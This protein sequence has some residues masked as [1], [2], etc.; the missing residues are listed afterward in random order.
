MITSR[1][2]ILLSI[3]S[4][5]GAYSCYQYE[6]AC[7]DSFAS[8][9][10]LSADVACEECCTYPAINLL[11][12]HQVGEGIPYGSDSILINNV[13]QKY[14]ISNAFLFLN[15]FEF[16][17]QDGEKVS[18]IEK[19]EFQDANRKT[20]ELISDVVFISVKNSS[21]KIGTMRRTGVIKKIKTS[22]GIPHS[23]TP[24]D[25]DHIL[26]KNDSL[27]NNNLYTNFVLEVRYGDDFSTIK[28]FELKGP[29]QPLEI[30]KDVDIL[31]EKRT[32]ISANAI[33]RYDLIAN[34]IDFET[35]NNEIF[36]DSIK[37]TDWLNFK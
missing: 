22:V 25:L 4:I 14:K 34:E 12:Q 29:N 37:K 17:F 3:L 20:E 24:T 16:S 21:H 30:I 10:N 2:I 19:A 6:D 36:Y 33:I 1:A 18:I 32:S 23:L 8:N 27:Y 15:E 31:K 13:G 28:R 26:F 35:A 7:L 9:Y 5:I 11:V